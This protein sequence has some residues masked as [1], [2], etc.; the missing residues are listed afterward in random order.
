MAHTF[1]HRSGNDA[2]I[3][4]YA[5]DRLSC[6]ALYT[7]LRAKQ[8]RQML[9]AS[10]RLGNVRKDHLEGR[11]VDERA[12]ERDRGLLMLLGVQDS[13]DRLSIF[14]HFFFSSIQSDGF[15]SARATASRH[16]ASNCSR[17]AVCIFG[18]NTFPPSTIA[19]NSSGDFQTPIARPASIAAPIAVVSA[20]FARRTGLP[21]IS[22]WNCIR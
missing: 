4:D 9:G 14:R 19:C 6:P 21:R 1:S 10:D 2:S 11:I 8:V 22:A 20:I 16:P 7:Q 18:V 12:A 13:N 15:V 17:S 5:E 3:I